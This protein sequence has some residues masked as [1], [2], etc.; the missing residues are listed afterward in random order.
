M[1]KKDEIRRLLAAALKALEQ[2]GEEP[3][4]R[5][6]RRPLEE[7]KRLFPQFVG[8]MK[9]CPRCKKEKEG[10]EGFGVRKNTSRPS[11]QSHCRACRSEQVPRVGDHSVT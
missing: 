2:D 5:M 11:L 6:T 9:V 10:L 3:T 4:P 8:K 1:P 7:L